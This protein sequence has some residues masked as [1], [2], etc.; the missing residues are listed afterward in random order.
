MPLAGPLVMAVPTAVTGPGTSRARGRLPTGRR[1]QGGVGGG[2]AHPAVVGEGGD[3]HVLGH[4]DEGDVRAAVR[5]DEAGAL[6]LAA[7]ADHRE[8]LEPAQRVRRGDD[9]A[10]FGDGDADERRPGRA[11]SWPGARPWTGRRRSAT[12]HRVLQR[13]ATWNRGG[14]AGVGRAAGRWGG[15][16]R[17]RAARRRRPRRRPRRRRADEDHEGAAVTLASAAA[18]RG[19]AR[20]AGALGLTSLGWRQSR[21]SGSIH[22]RSGLSGSSGPL[23]PRRDPGSPSR[24]PPACRSPGRGYRDQSW[25]CRRARGGPYHEAPCRATWPSISGRPTRSS[26]RKERASSSTSPPWSR[27][28]RGAARCWPSGPMPGR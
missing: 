24:A 4:L 13:R 15:P 14:H 16:R 7:G 28:I 8:V 6:E 21:S 11:T 22:P 1:R 23:P 9:E 17:A 10:P 18:C 26:T 12:R 20:L 19:R 25:L 3:G 2:G 27:W 5:A